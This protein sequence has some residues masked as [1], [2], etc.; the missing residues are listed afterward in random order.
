[1]TPPLV[2][3]ITLNWNHPDDTIACLESL[4][5]QTYP[6]LRLL[7]VDNGS[8]DDSITKIQAAC[9]TVALLARSDNGG[10]ARG[11]NTGIRQ[12][13][14]AGADFTF[15]VNNDTY[16]APD[17]IARLVSAA[18]PDIGL[19]APIIYYADEPQRVWSI[20]ALFN[21][22]LLEPKE[23]PRGMIDAG[24]WQSYLERDFVPAC[25]LLV[26]R[27]VWERV[28]LFDERFFMYYEDLDFCLRLHRVGLRAIV[29][30]QA[31][32]WH[33]VS[34]SSGGYGSPR[35]RYA[36]ARSSVLYFRK[37]TRF[38]Q[39][40]L[41]GF[42]RVGSAVQTTWRLLRAGKW[43]ALRAYWRGLWHGVRWVPTN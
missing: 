36:M 14:A 6:N 37:H 31:K 12:A 43:M 8:Q 35:E 34:L 7:V 18:Q 19:I 21:P 17:A 32:M 38:W 20:G 26:S 41:I 4:V 5:A 1:M 2:Y 28:G 11:M 33:K 16:L 9:P 42:W 22:W 39:W 15:L 30:P 29:V 13:L 27:P 3:A 25:G 24:Q 40:P 10:F 23:N